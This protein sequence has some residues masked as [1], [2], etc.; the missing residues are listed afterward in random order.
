MHNESIQEALQPFIYLAHCYRCADVTLIDTYLP[1]GIAFIN[2]YKWM[3]TDLG[4]L[5]SIMKSINIANKRNDNIA[6][7]D[8]FEYD[9]CEYLEQQLCRIKLQKVS[10]YR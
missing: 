8:Y 9:L 10:N 3:F 6:V 1:V 5:I 2:E 4:R 7:A